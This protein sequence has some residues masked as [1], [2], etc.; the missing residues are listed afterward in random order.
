M[1]MSHKFLLS[2]AL[3]ALVASSIVTVVQ[4]DDVI[5]WLPLSTAT[6]D[7][8]VPNTGNQQTSS[9]VLDVDGDGLNDFVIAERSQA[10]SLMWYRRQPDGWDRYVVDSDRLPIEAGGSFADIDGDGDLDV[11]FGGDSSSN[12]VWWWENPMPDFDPAVPWNRYL[13]KDSGSSKHHDQAFGDFDGDNTLE[14]AF[15]NQFAGGKLCVAEVPADPRNTEP[16]P[17]VEVFDGPDNAEGMDVADVDGDGVDDIVGAGYWF[18]HTGGG[19]Y[20]ANLIVAGRAFTR[21]AVGDLIPGGRPEVVIAPGDANGAIDYYE[22]DGAAWIGYELRSYI[23]HGHS[24]A[25]GDIDLDGNLDI[26]VGEMGNPGDGANCDTLVYYGDGTGFFDEQY[27]A[28]GIANHESRLEDLDG[29]GDL[30]ILAKPYNYGA[31]RLDIFLNETLSPAEVGFAQVIIDDPD[32]AYERIVGDID[33]DG[34]NDI[35][36]TP[37]APAGELWLYRAPSF[38]R[39]VVLTL[40]SGT[41]GWPYF[42][43]D[44]VQLADFDLDGDLDV[45]GRIGDGGDVNGKV[46]WIENPLTGCHD[47]SGTWIVHEVGVNAYTKDIVVADFDDDN[48]IDIATRE[49]DRTQIWFN[50]GPD[51]WVRREV[52]HPTHEGLDVGDLDDDGDPDLVLN[53]YWLETPADPRTGGYVQHDIDVKWFTQ[54]VGWE[55]NSCKVVVADVDGDAALDVVFSH[56]E[57]TGYPVSWYSASDPH[58]GPWTEHIIVPV[59]DDCHNLQAA[60]FN[61][62]G[63]IDVLYGGMPQSAQRGLHVM[64]GDGGVTWE[65]FEI[66]DAGSYSAEIGDIDD[67]GDW[68]IVGI[69]NWNAGPTEIWRNTLYEPV[70]AFTLDQWQ[71]IQVDDSRVRWQGSLAYFGLGWGDLTGDGY[72]DL[73]SGRYFY[74]NPGGDMSAAPW[75]RVEFSVGANVDASLVVDVDGDAYGDVIASTGPQIYWLEADD[76]DGTTWSAYLIDDDAP[77]EAGHVIPQGYATADIIPGGFPEVLFNNGD[78]VYYYE[79]PASSPETGDWPMTIVLDNSNSED[80]GIADIDR[81]GRLDIAAAHWT[82]SGAKSMKWA[83]NPG[84]GSAYWPEYIVGE[85]VPSGGGQYPDRVKAADLNGDGRV[86]I[87]CTEEI[88]SDPASTYWFEA[89]ADPTEVPWTRHT[90]VTQYTTNSMDIADM[91]NDGDIDLITQEH[92]GTEKLQVWENDGC[93]NFTE[94]LIDS[95]KEGHLGARVADLDQD[96]DYEIFSIAFDSYQYLHLWRNDN[97]PGTGPVNRPP[98]AQDDSFQ[99]EPSDTYSG[100]LV[101]SD[102]DPL[103]TLEYAIVDLPVEGSLISFDPQSGAFTYEAPASPTNDVFT[104]EAFD[105]EL[106]SNV[107]TV[108]VTVQEINELPVAVIQVDT[109]TPGA[110]PAEVLFDATGSYDPDGTI[111]AYVWDFDDGSISDQSIVQHTFA[112]NRVYN[113]TLTVT[114]NEGGIDTEAVQIYVGAIDE[115]LIGYWPFDEDAGTVA[116][117]FSGYGND[118]T[119]RDGAG[120]GDGLFGAA[121]SLDGTGAYASRPDAQL[122]GGFPAQSDG[123]GEDFTISAWI[124]LNRLNHRHPIVQKQGDEQRGLNFTVEPDNQ[125]TCELF[126]DPFSETEFGG[127]TPLNAQTWHH[128]ALTY[129]FISDGTSVAHLYLDGQLVGST[130]SAVGPIAPNTVDLN[131]GRY[132]WSASYERYLDGRIDEVR[133]YD[134]ALAAPEIAALSDRPADGDYNNDGVV[135]LTD[136]LELLDC[137]DGPEVPIS[138]ACQAAFDYDEDLDVDVQDLATFQVQYA[139]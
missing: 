62:D 114:D 59:C 57:Y 85:V 111:D 50:D 5:D 6:G 27:V 77:Y 116:A 136:A 137:L 39:E 25:I 60:D 2:I 23:V 35:I 112:A 122:S 24:L 115:G 66:Q 26:F 21:T 3:R 19:A 108:A 68:D 102:P 13:I 121:L 37:H 75:S 64:L 120:W 22:W 10:P 17:Y 67:D 44:D 118:A 82:G 72:L 53:G 94:R 18:G 73:V 129:D 55:S 100:T 81:D 34:R 104:F 101:A 33:G 32:V 52:S 31:P 16:W 93:G 15:W 83:R 128:V 45:A 109:T 88:S 70:P 119:L 51:T 105:G 95:G 99:V 4:A 61:D 7:L 9:L 14:L 130:A 36:A 29:D 92:R 69:R 40:D 65:F 54:S 47:V 103:D 139:P 49:D 97:G 133:I 86:D 113:V 110:A 58:N 43:A 80:I 126:S 96:G 125:L 42:R 134:R 91:D 30:D 127:A 98:V 20:S 11:S 79:I 84:D 87:V 78:V 117:D 71:Y 123:S 106:W 107:A 89:P 12:R 48:R 135:D 131:F 41:H 38:V 56:S 124:Y 63:Y 46:V 8:A 76:I 90:I 1:G 138:D 74:R 132:R 28:T